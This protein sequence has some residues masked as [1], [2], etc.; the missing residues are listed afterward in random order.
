MASFGGLGSILGD[1]AGEVAGWNVPVISDIAGYINGASDTQK[2]S[3]G[4]VI[5]DIGSGIGDAFSSF[6]NGVSDVLGGISS[7]ISDVSSS[8][9]SFID[10]I[11]DVIR[12]TTDLVNQIN[13]EVIKP[14]VEPIRG[15]I[16][17][18][19]ALMAEIRRDL[20]AGIK[21]LLQLPQD[22]TNAL[23]SVDAIMQ[24]T[25][26]Q[27]SAANIETINKTVVPALMGAA[28][29]P[30]G[31]LTKIFTD[32]IQKFHEQEKDL[33]PIRLPE[34]VNLTDYQE[35]LIKGFERFD[36]GTDTITVWCR[37]L[38]TVLSWPLYFQYTNQHFLELLAEQAR[39]KHP[40]SRL[41]PSQAIEAYR[42][43]VIPAIEATQEMESAGFDTARIATLSR[44]AEAQPSYAQIVEKMRRDI[45]TREQAN[46]EMQKLGYTADEALA[47]LVASLVIP[48]PSQIQQYM[49]RGVIDEEGART[50]YKWLG[51]DVEETNRA[52]AVSDELPSLSA[53]VE[54]VV[55][56]EAAKAGIAT[57]SLTSIPPDSVLR[58][59]RQL[60]LSSESIEAAW[61]NHWT[62]LPVN[63]ITAAYFKG[64]I[65][66]SQLIGALRSAA[67]PDDLHAVWID[68]QRPLIP[69][70]TIPSMLVHNVI[71]EVQAL[72]LLEAQGFSSVDAELYIK[73][74]KATET[75]SPTTADESL[76]GLTQSTILNLYDQG[77]IERSAT[78]KLLTDIG[79][80][81][82]AAA[83]A[84]QLVDIKTQA[85][86]RAA[87]V[88]FV[89]AQAKAN[90]LTTDQA[91]QEL[92][93]AG[94][95]NTE[96]T[97]AVS[98]LLAQTRVKDKL[99][100]RAELDQM[101]NA[102]VLGDADYADALNT[103]GYSTG[104]AQR[105]LALNKAKAAIPPAG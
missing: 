20:D 14:I 41:T 19:D 17:T 58:A 105:F 15:I 96:V 104:W 95:T 87:L 57:Q 83:L 85:E 18:V 71:D 59:G 30:L 103:L 21:G 80:G 55:R 42:R 56:N 43:G 74:A 9:K 13:D 34:D 44:L 62:L 98:K 46:E 66:H 81:I 38:L 5:S 90:V 49:H 73:Y 54:N 51:Y 39:R 61:T 82:E 24:R 75:T 22:I 86:E 36:N 84:V 89:I 26:Q 12:E 16:E 40:T 53:I 1:V 25:V 101:Y 2:N 6:S 37:N 97:K 32:P 65:N 47:L 11:A 63:L 67:V 100:T 52:L 33:P 94:L 4:E 8:V 69:S 70:R 23:N 79:I 88:D 29:A 7:I 77:A 76:H 72:R 93:A 78:I 45:I 68:M 48:G 28:S 64:L 10:P 31:D 92:F 50:F 91:Q 102:G 60:G 27:L 35:R 3:V 99:P